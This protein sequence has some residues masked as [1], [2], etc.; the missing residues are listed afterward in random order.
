M[1]INPPTTALEKLDFPAAITIF[2]TW[3]AGR[4]TCRVAG[5]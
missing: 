5:L 2:G 1:R 4:A 3:K